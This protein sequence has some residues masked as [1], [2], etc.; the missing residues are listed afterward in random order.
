MKDLIILTDARGFTT[1]CE[2]TT[3]AVAREITRCALLFPI[4][5]VRWI[6]D[7]K[8]TE[9]QGWRSVPCAL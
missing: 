6:R 1:I 2:P 5:Q 4:S 9:R 3:H 7:F 8:D